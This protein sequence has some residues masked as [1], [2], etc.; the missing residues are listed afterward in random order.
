MI[1]EPVIESH[2]LDHVVYDGVVTAGDIRWMVEHDLLEVDPDRQR[3]KN[4]VTKKQVLKNAKVDR[5]ARDLIENKAVFGQL[6]LNFRPEESN[7][8][9]DE[10]AGQFVIEDGRATAP[11]SVHRI[12]SI[13]EAAGSAA[14]GSTFDLNRKFSV[15]I[16]TVPAETENEIFYWM[17]Q[18][19]DKADAT[20]SK[21]L[22]QRNTGQKIAR[23]V[24]QQS[25][26]LTEKNVET[27]SNTLAKKNPRLVAFNTL[28]VAFEDAWADIPEADIDKVVSWFV[29]YWKKL[30]D[31]RPELR[32]VSSYT[33]RQ[34]Y[35]SGS[36]AA[37]AIAIHGYVRLARTF[38]DKKLSL[39][40]L[41][42]LNNKVKVKKGEGKD[43]VEVEVDFFAFDNPLW[44]DNAV[45]VTKVSKDG[46]VTNAVPNTRDTRRTMHVLMAE[47]IGVGEAEKAAT[48]PVTAA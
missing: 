18:E 45:L 20:R 14:K 28:A 22:A 15:R 26:L 10:T 12:L 34:K 24:I 38:Y 33:D 27:V 21:Y 6:T 16:W 46:K 37:W 43:E 32:P 42:G 29:G 30:A 17:N 44:A 41:D 3:G 8:Y 47:Y 11:D 1:I 35:R 40:L 48:N 36:L 2:D 7:V 9:Y 31:L 23:A 25:P 39:N 4:S 13:V 19:G 5:W